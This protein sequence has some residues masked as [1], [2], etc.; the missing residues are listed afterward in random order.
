MLSTTLAL[1]P[2]KQQRSC[3]AHLR[4]RRSTAPCNMSATVHT[5]S[6]GVKDGRLKDAA[7][8]R[9][10][11]THILSRALTPTV[12]LME[13]TQA[14]PTALFLQSVK[15]RSVFFFPWDDDGSP[16]RSAPSLLCY[17]KFPA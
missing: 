12:K 4:P 14:S 6:P 15:R 2:R 1:P 16:R 9:Q 7:S 10:H 17:F 8:I 3:L 13:V 5:A 11:H